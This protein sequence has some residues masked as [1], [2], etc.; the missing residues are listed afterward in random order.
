MSGVQVIFWPG[1]EPA[2]LHQPNTSQ[3]LTPLCFMPYGYGTHQHRHALKLSTEVLIVNCAQLLGVPVITNLPSYLQL[4]LYLR[5][6][7]VLQCCYV[8]TLATMCNN[9]VARDENGCSS[10]GGCYSLVAS[11]CFSGDRKRGAALSKIKTS[12]GRREERASHVGQEEVLSLFVE[13]LYCTI[14]LNA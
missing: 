8:A 14:D 12:I 9:V 13:N 4:P 1:C 10:T 6:R 7:S 3:E 11:C 2:Q 5:A